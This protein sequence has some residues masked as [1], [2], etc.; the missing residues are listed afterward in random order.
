[1]RKTHVAPISLDRPLRD[2]EVPDGCAQVLLVP[3]W[4]GEI[5]GESLV[6][7][8][9]RL[10]AEA[11]R[12]AL[13]GDVADRLLRRRLEVAFRRAAGAAHEPAEAPPVR[14]VSVVVC[15]RPGSERRLDACLASLHRLRRAPDEIVV[16]A[17]SHLARARNRGA[18]AAQGEVIAFTQDDCRVGPGWL[19]GVDGAFSDVLVMAVAGYVGFE[20]LT[21]RAD[22]A[23]Y[24]QAAT[25]R[26][27][28]S[29]NLL[30][31]RQAFEQLGLFREEPG[32]DGSPLGAVEAEFAD[33]V[34]RAGYRLAFDP[35]RV[36]WQGEAGAQRDVRRAVRRAAA[37]R[38]GH[39]LRR[40]LRHGDPGPTSAGLRRWWRIALSGGRTGG[41]GSPRLPTGVALAAQTGAAA[42]PWALA[43]TA[44]RRAPA[45]LLE[46]SAPVRT[47]SS[48]TVAEADHPHL[49]VA[50]ASYNR[51][52]EL[53]GALE[54][55]GR[56]SYPVER[57][58]AVVVLDGSTDGS[59]EMV[60]AAETPYQLRLIEQDNRGLGASRNHGAREASYPLVVFLDDDAFPDPDFL[61]QHAAAH[62]EAPAPSFVLGYTPPVVREEGLW[63]IA[64]RNWWEDFFR[65]RTEPGHR[66]TFMDVADGN[67]SISRSLFLDC[68]GF[69][70]GMERRHDWEFG[71][72]IIERAV[73]LVHCHE[74]VAWHHFDTSFAAAL[75][76]RRHEGRADIPFARRH[77]AAKGRLF[78]AAFAGLDGRE[79]AGRR[80]LAYRHPQT[81]EPFARAGVVA[82]H[83]LEALRLRRAWDRLSRMLLAH[84]YLRGVADVLPSVDDF[85]AFMAPALA[86]EGARTLDVDLD[87]AV[88]GSLPEPGTGWLRLV[89]RLA[90]TTV[91][92]VVTPEPGSQWD[93]ASLTERVVDECAA[94]V[95]AAA[96]EQA[97]PLGDFASRDLSMG[98]PA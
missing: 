94:A 15:A 77:P 5:L 96:P 98:T 58:E 37:G 65:R 30:V 50:M 18:I 13:R 20:A 52:R 59:A 49:T 26:G 48:V 60:R 45:A 43:R 69:D 79:M 66:W 90:G 21:T 53:A 25:L 41:R 22:W 93:W 2:L 61:A 86:G 4:R 10:T 76:N 8:R 17:D 36:V 97:E 85:R 40:L 33:R 16:E 73:P 89:L 70:E 31:R 87:G 3:A 1:M 80:A 35:A 88:P 78:L 57:F 32:G 84:A 29:R 63:S 83:L 42:A 12:A 71:A 74:A 72:R 9:G 67:S 95:G 54:A 81:A 64:I 62:R 14:A 47:G 34:V 38:A 46:P 92:T 39:A 7:A 6:R 19:D 68:D 75:A 51:R 28:D 11:Q 56:Q 23:A 82:L 24:A 44:I 91:G 27:I 55:L